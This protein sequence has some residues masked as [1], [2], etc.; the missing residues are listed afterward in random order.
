MA[1]RKKTANT[2]A[3]ARSARLKARPAPAKAKR[4]AGKPARA[5]AR[6]GMRKG[7]GASAA[8]RGRTGAGISRAGVRRPKAP[9]AA[10]RPKEKPSRA[11]VP[12]SRRAAAA[13]GTGAA[14]VTPQAA[15]G[16]PELSV[17]NEALR[18][19]TG[20]TWAQWFAAL[21][22]EGARSLPHSDILRLVFQRF[23]LN[24][25][26]SQTVTVGY[27]QTH[28]LRGKQEQA[29]GYSASA[30]K[31][32]AAAPE[33]VYA[34]WNADAERGRWLGMNLKVRSATP[35]KSIRLNWSDPISQIVVTLNPRGAGKT[36]VAVEHSRLK[37]RA[38]S[39]RMR[40]FWASALERLGAAV[41]GR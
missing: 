16:Q 15:A 14:A 32:L 6:A 13:T 22:A 17:G 4:A 7:A 30:S 38:E 1:Q 20:R 2:K 34:A 8:K 33:R 19:A 9:A 36:Q 12:P 40:T 27:E 41:G 31:T 11:A 28:G 39:A 3:A 23:R 24:P 26:W 21:D 37:D 10:A 25:G 5:K 18:Q 35:P 29:E